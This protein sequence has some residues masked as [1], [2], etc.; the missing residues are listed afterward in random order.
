MRK[1]TVV[2]EARVDPEY[3]VTY[4]AAADWF[5][6]L[7]DAQISVEETMEWQRLMVS[8]RRFAIAYSRVEEV[9]N[10]IGDVPNPVVAAVRSEMRDRYDGSVPISEWIRAQ[11]VWKRPGRLPALLAAS[12]AGIALA[13]YSLFWGTTA[14]VQI[15]QTP[16]GHNLAFTLADGSRLN[17]GADTRLEIRFNSASRRISITRGEA[18]FAVA[19]D[20][21]R[22]FI[23]GAGDATV[24]AVG[25]EFSVNRGADEVV[26]AVIE[27][28]VVVDAGTEASPDSR[29][30]SVKTQLS[31][32]QQILV[33]AAGTGSPASLSNVTVAL[34]WQNDRLAF[35]S[36]PLSRVLVDVNRY[37]SKPISVDDSSI[38][39]LMITGTVVRDDVSGWL[40][41]LEKAFPVRVVEDSHRITIR[42]RQ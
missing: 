22:P 21:N 7:H 36:E 18:F 11:R 20:R 8:D 5:A 34:G 14:A 2:R 1:K 31:A 16:V 9:W 41:S 35:Q 15:L 28:R 24:T 12:L 19:K 4:A 13:A 38:G 10:A 6:R 33:S 42:P 39:D 37:T 27:G 23:V 29:P 30:D 3:D 25:T 40:A 26:I 17:L 32:G